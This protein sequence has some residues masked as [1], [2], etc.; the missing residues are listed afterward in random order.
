MILTA[1]KEIHE[2]V[3]MR[4]SRKTEQRE[5]AAKLFDEIEKD[6]MDFVKIWRSKMSNNQLS[7]ADSTDKLN[8]LRAVIKT[9]ADELPHNMSAV[10]G[11]EKA[12]KLGEVL[13]KAHEAK[14]LLILKNPE[15][16]EAK[17]AILSEAAGTFHAT[18]AALRAS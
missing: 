6:L 15:K 4:S 8:K 16:A 9:F 5:K 2:F 13:K 10:L 18:A 7:D 3:K 11:Q 17:L 14:S 1:A 12:E